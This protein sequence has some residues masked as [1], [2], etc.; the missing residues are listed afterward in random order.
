ME[1]EQ[2]TVGPASVEKQNWQPALLLLVRRESDEAIRQRCR[3][4]EDGAAT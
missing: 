3:S 1:E 2:R 4:R